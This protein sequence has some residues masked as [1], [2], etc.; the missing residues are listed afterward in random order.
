M[1]PFAIVIPV[2]NVAL[3]KLITILLR[4]DNDSSNNDSPDKD[5]SSDDE[6]S[7]DEAFGEESEEE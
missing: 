4:I 1:L 7:S 6:I 3:P 5:A 2:A